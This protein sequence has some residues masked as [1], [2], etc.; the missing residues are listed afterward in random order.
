[1]D[2]KGISKLTDTEITIIKENL[3]RFTF[4]GLG[5][6]DSIMNQ[7]SSFGCSG[8]SYKN[9][10][11]ALVTCAVFDVQSDKGLYILRRHFVKVSAFSLE[12]I[13]VI[14]EAVLDRLICERQGFYDAMNTL[15][16]ENEG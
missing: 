6:K 3:S 4:K 8:V 5:D 11:G 13:S 2:N 1:M 10:E 12:I 15:D 16:K 9:G 14:D 7:G